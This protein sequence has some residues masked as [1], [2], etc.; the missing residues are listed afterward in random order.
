MSEREELAYG[1]WKEKAANW[2]A[3]STICAWNAR[4]AI[5]RQQDAEI[6]A[7]IAWA[8]KAI[9]ASDCV[10]QDRNYRAEA[11]DKIREIMKGREV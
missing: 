6:M 7:V 10:M 5:H 11:F 2:R 9:D 3:N 4:A 1:E 8:D